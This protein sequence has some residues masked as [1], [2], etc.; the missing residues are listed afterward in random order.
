KA[1]VL[2]TTY[3]WGKPQPRPW[4]GM[5]SPADISGTQV[6][7]R[8]DQVPILGSGNRKKDLMT[9]LHLSRLCPMQTIICSP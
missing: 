5:R 8:K 2:F 1:A 6:S 3:Q 4:R 9:I 7:R